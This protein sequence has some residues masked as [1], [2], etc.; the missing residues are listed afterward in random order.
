M[1]LGASA[2]CP[3]YF[4]G[5]DTKYD[6]GDS[7]TYIWTNNGSI[8]VV[9]APPKPYGFLV[10]GGGAAGH[11]L[12]TAGGAGG[13]YYF[14]DSNVHAR[15]FF[16]D[17]GVWSV[18]VGN[19]G[20]GGSDGG[21]TVVTNGGARIESF[22][23]TAGNGSGGVIY[24]D[25]LGATGMIYPNS[26]GANGPNG[27]GGGA[28]SSGSGGAASGTTGGAGGA[29]TTI[30]W[31]PVIVAAGGG[32]W[33]SV[34]SGP[35]GSGN[36]GGIGARG[37]TNLIAPTNANGLSYGSGGGAG[38]IH[39]APLPDPDFVNGGSGTQGIVM[40]NYPK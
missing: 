14:A 15:K 2:R 39:D 30:A 29:G 21:S 26:H 3:E 13:V 7:W 22:G 36:M 17:S 1:I 37:T 24:T 31:W 8:T 4:L 12:I 5:Y 6:S 11:S 28:G 33:G 18:T 35:G 34:S 38:A 10:V 20:T 16:I 25:A 27:S 23:G 40:I 32:G 9:K 19:A